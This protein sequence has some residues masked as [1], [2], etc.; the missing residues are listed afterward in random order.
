MYFL[1]LSLL[2][3]L[4]GEVFA[5]STLGVGVFGMDL[6]IVTLWIGSGLVRVVICVTLGDGVVWFGSSVWGGFA[7]LSKVTRFCT[8]GAV[9]SPSVGS[10]PGELLRMLFS[11]VKASIWS[12]SC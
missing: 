2:S 4:V 7:V 5:V 6:S 8:A 1:I 3:L 10:V 9:G 11:L 12:I